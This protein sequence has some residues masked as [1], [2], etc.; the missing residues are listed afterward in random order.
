M[1]GHAGGSTWTQSV[2][3]WRDGAQVDIM[4]SFHMAC[5]IPRTGAV[6]TADTSI[7]ITAKQP[8]LQH[9]HP[10]TYHRQF[11]MLAAPPHVLPPYS[12]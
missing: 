12:C 9:A 1:N 10:C 8:C 4:D 7:C 3:V 2:H 5:Y 11:S 6:T